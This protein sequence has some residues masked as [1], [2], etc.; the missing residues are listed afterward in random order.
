MNVNRTATYNGIS[1]AK[2]IDNVVKFTPYIFDDFKIYFGSSPL[3]KMSSRQADEYYSSVA[4]IKEEFKTA[5]PEL[6][7]QR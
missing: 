5:K 3:D 2:E 1:K 6:V 7:Q 4:A